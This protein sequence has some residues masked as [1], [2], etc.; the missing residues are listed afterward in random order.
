MSEIRFD[1]VGL[2][3]AI[4]DVLSRTDDSFLEKWGIHKDAMNLIEH[5]RLALPGDPLRRARRDSPR[6]LAVSGASWWGWYHRLCSRH[7]A[8]GHA[9]AVADSRSRSS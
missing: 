4:V 1:V 2:G 9:V 8:A 5:V 6:G 7:L 3:N